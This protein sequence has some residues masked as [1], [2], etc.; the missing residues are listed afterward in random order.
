MGDEISI[1]VAIVFT[2]N[3]DIQ[4]PGTGH[5][6]SAR[7]EEVEPVT[8]NSG[9][10]KNDPEKFLFFREPV[11]GGAVVRGTIATV[12]CGNGYVYGQLHS[13]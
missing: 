5:R 6:G 8:V 12:K 1:S 3:F 2:A 13:P 7:L 11:P 4:R 9:E 10:T